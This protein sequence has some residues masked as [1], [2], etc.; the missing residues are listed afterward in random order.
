MLT[1]KPHL[2]S[3][4]QNNFILIKIVHLLHVS[5]CD[6]VIISTIELSAGK[7]RTATILWPTVCYGIQNRQPYKRMPRRAAPRR[8]APSA[9]HSVTC[10]FN[11]QE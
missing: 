2:F 9:M 5:A 3:R 4:T 11:A 6:Y 8:A 10:I 1:N 7:R